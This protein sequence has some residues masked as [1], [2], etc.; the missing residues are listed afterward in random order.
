M[1]NMGKKKHFCGVVRPTDDIRYQ[2]VN[3]TKNLIKHHLL[4]MQI[5][6]L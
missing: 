6:N 3:K 4:L 5:S 2:R 1:K